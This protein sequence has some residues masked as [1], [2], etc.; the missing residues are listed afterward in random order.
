MAS[1]LILDDDITWICFQGNQDF[2]YMNRVLTNTPLADSEDDFLEE[3]KNYFPHLYDIKYMKHEY[4]EL[5]GGLQRTADNLRLDRIGQMH[6]AGSDSWLT[7]LIYFKMMNTYLSN[8]DKNLYNNIL[9]G[10][11]ISENDDPYLDNYTSRTD[12]IEREAREYGER[13]N[14]DDGDYMHPVDQYQYRNQGFNYNQPMGHD[15]QQQIAE[16]N[17]FGNQPNRDQQQDYISQDVAGGY[18]NPSYSANHMLHPGSHMPQNMNNGEGVMPMA[19][20]MHPAGYGMSPNNLEEYDHQYPVQYNQRMPGQVPNP[21][22][23]DHYSNPG[24]YHQ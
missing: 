13:N 18:I 19:Q 10:L 1:G 5:R 9:Y 16:P 22:Q 8:K 15:Y 23:M 3:T 12:Q 17:Y 20:N 6:Q 7:G 24:Y 2:G 11:G 21:N 14:F 4:E